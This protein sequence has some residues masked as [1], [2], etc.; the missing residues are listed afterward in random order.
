MPIALYRSTIGTHIV[1]YNKA[2]AKVLSDCSAALPS[3]AL[4]GRRTK[5]EIKA[6]IVRQSTCHSPTVSNRSLKL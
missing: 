2:S 1:S 5:L 6:Q 3:M 4:K